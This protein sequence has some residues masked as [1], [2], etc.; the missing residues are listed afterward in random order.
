M[1]RLSLPLFSVFMIGLVALCTHEPFMGAVPQRASVAITKDVKENPI[2]LV[3]QTNKRVYRRGEPIIFT[4]YL[5]NVSDKYFYVGCRLTGFNLHA[6]QVI[7]L[8]AVDER[9]RELERP[10]LYA[11]PSPL[12]LNKPVSEKIAKGYV[13]LRPR[14]IHGF[15]I[16]GQVIRKPGRYRYTAI[17]RE[18]E[19]LSWKQV[20]RDAL[21]IQV[22][23]EPIVS[24]TVTITVLPRT[25]ISTKRKRL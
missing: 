5:E 14:M 17:Y 21:P 19:A 9:N 1:S 3:L 6:S 22:W 4:V 7:E 24:K 15:K 10:S 2:R 13:N 8:K 20:E 25:S 23:T 11:D 18:I 16:Y 12:E